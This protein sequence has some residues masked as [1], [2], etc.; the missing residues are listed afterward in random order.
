M[1][2][3][4]HT[5]EGL[6]D[7]D[8]DIN[9]ITIEELINTVYTKRMTKKQWEE[10]AKT[11][12]MSFEPA[13]SSDC[14]QDYFGTIEVFQDEREVHIHFKPPGTRARG[15]GVQMN[16]MEIKKGKIKCNRDG[17]H[18]LLKPAYQIPETQENE[19]YLQEVYEAHAKKK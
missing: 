11:I 2:S 6:L 1:K 7:S 5:L 13:D 3:L 4:L 10:F 15:F 16:S 17:C 9:L 12:D 19:C 8:F 18:W 14:A